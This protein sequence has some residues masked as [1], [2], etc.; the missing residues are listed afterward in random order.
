MKNLVPTLQ[1]LDG[2]PLVPGKVKRKYEGLKK[3]LPKPRGSSLPDQADEPKKKLKTFGEDPKTPSKPTKES[4]AEDAPEK[5]FLELINPKPLGATGA[6]KKPSDDV[7][8]EEDSG[9]VAVIE[10]QKKREA[11]GVW[12]R[13][14]GV[15][16]LTAMAKEVEVG[17]GGA[18][19]WDD[20]PM[21]MN[22]APAVEAVAA[23]A[24]SYSRW[25]LKKK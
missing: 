24:T 18:S 22:R 25:A 4:Q 15:E 14:R 8:P 3:P 7:R 19:T 11:V 23:T 20:M 5:P 6:K 2:H 13:K 16:A 21:P 17:A 10:G 12:K 1:I 9:L